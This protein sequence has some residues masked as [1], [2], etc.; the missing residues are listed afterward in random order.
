MGFTI[1]E[2]SRRSGVH[3]ETIRYYERLGLLGPVSRSASGRRLFALPDLETL[4]FIRH[5]REMLF[6]I[7]HI[8]SLLPLRAKGACPGVKAIATAHLSELRAKLKTLATLE[9]KLGAAVSQ[10]RGDASAQ[11]S[12]IALLS[13]PERNLGL[14]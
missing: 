12:I 2:L 4:Q 7:E 8:R 6:G 14:A 11:C 13:S 9:K 3:I 10:C 1:G 5:C